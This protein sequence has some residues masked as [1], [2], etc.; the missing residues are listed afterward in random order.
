MQWCNKYVHPKVDTRNSLEESKSMLN[1]FEPWKSGEAEQAR[2]GEVDANCQRC[3]DLRTSMSSNKTN[4]DVVKFFQ[5][6]NW[7]S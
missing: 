6:A 2:I 5:R 4:L 3:A 1:R 7:H